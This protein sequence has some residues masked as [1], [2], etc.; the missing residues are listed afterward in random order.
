MND[1]NYCL[2]VI[3]ACM[4]TLAI[5]GAGQVIV[6]GFA[7]ALAGLACISPAATGP[8]RHGRRDRHEVPR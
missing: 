6:A 4:L 3:L 1:D 2:F 8:G 5:P 7:F